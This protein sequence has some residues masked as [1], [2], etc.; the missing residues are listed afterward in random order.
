MERLERAIRAE[1]PKA[2]LH[3]CPDTERAAELASKRRCDVCF[4]DLRQEESAMLRFARELKDRFPS[5]NLIFIE[6]EYRNMREAMELRISGYLLESAV[7]EAVAR[8]LRELRYP[9]P[10]A[11]DCL[12]SVRCA[13]NF[14][15]FLPDGTR[16]RFAR[17][18]SKEVLAYLVHRWG[19]ACTVREIAA[20][21]F[22]DAPYDLQQQRYMQKIL[23]TLR[24]TLQEAGAADAI[25]KSYNSLALNTRMVES[26]VRGTYARENLGRGEYMAQ[27]SWADFGWKR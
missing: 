24:K 19:A 4:L 9:L 13:G 3:V 10:A 1:T 21:L 7:P 22:E 12:L 14:D 27:Y 23:G 6:S 16:L 20:I 11:E 18:K 15:V 25:H 5:V 2:E 17:S 26:D 8:E